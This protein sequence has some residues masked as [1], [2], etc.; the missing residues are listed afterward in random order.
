MHRPAFL[1][2]RIIDDGDWRLFLG[3][4]E[5]SMFGICRGIKSLI[6]DERFAC[7]SLLQ[8]RDGGIVKLVSCPSDCH[9]HLRVWTF[10]SI[11]LIREQRTGITRIIDLDDHNRLPYLLILN[12]RT[13]V[14]TVTRFSGR[15]DP[16]CFVTI[17]W[18]QTTFCLLKNY[19]CPTFIRV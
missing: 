12:K 17:T 19:F 2:A 1:A 5:V 18:W 3:S 7:M 4:T 15:Y 11:M 9:L 16:T 13:K 6:R 14:G 10:N 8:G